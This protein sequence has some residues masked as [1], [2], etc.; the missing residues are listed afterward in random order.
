MSSD[1]PRIRVLVVDDENRFRSNVERLLA[2][3]GFGVACVAN[4]IEALEL[5]AK[6]TFDVIVLDQKMPGM[7]GLATMTRL[8]EQG[9]QAKVI[10]LTGHTSMD[11][12]TEGMDM[13]AVDYLLK[14]LSMEDL[15]RKI[16]EVH[17]GKQQD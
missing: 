7:D 1:A 5:T 15:A 17:T 2:A 4:G 9:C 10:F 12:A 11:A 6:E 3:K 13:G 8:K 14:P 16:V